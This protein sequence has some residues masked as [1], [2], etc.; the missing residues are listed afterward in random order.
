[1]KGIINKNETDPSDS[2]KELQ[3][4]VEEI[5]NYVKKELMPDDEHHIMR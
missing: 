4:F 5:A 3:K 2:I 1:M